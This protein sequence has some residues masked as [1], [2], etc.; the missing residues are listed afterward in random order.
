VRQVIE[1][2]VLH[3]GGKG[4]S[5]EHETAITQVICYFQTA[6]ERRAGIIPDIAAVGSMALGERRIGEEV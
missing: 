3:T 1:E 4:M 2:Q 5:F 6:V